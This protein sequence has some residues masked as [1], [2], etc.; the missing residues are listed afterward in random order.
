M[1]NEKITDQAWATYR[2]NRNKYTSELH[3]A[4]ENYYQV[5][6]TH[7]MIKI[8]FR[9]KKWWSI[10]E[11]FLGKNTDS[12]VPPISDGKNVAYTNSEM[13]TAYNKFFYV[14]KNLKIPIRKLLHIS[15]LSV[16]AKM[17]LIL[18]V[19]WLLLLTFFSM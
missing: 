9:V 7:C 8:I 13:A 14:T 11:S 1:P 4:E 5:Y 16:M 18:T 2:L 12:A 3:S 6:V 15:N 10:A 17:L 19:K